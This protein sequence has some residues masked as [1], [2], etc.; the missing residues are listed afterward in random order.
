MGIATDATASR[1]RRATT[2][3]DVRSRQTAAPS[4]T[5]SSTSTIVISRSATGSTAVM[6]VP[7]RPLAGS[8][9]EA[10]DSVRRR[11][12]AEER[13]EQSDQHEP[14]AAIHR[15]P[16]VVA[17]TAR[18]GR[19]ARVLASSQRERYR[20]RTSARRAGCARLLRSRGA[21]ERRGAGRRP[22]G[23]RRRLQPGRVAPTDRPSQRS[24]AR[25]GERM[26]VAGPLMR[27]SP[28]A[29]GPR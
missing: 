22:E 16:A 2:H 20:P 18:D 3:T 19:H 17:E 4:L 6:A 13:Q 11:D 14:E 8:V 24:S 28:G 7:G 26:S 15:E 1:R 21:D 25:G 12:G 29:T 10:L 9:S 27:G 23:R 5:S